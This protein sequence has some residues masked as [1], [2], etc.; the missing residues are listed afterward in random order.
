M[1]LADEREE[2]MK[3]SNCVVAVLVFFSFIAG[4]SFSAPGDLDLT[5]DSP[6]NTV[7]VL[8]DGLK[9][10]VAGWDEGER[11]LLLRRHNIDGTLDDTFGTGGVA[12]YYSQL[13][14]DPADFIVANA[15]AIQRD[16]K[17]VVVGG[18]YKVG[19]NPYCIVLRFTRDGGLD[20]TFGAEGAVIFEDSA[21]GGVAV[22]IQS[23]NKILV[24]TY[25]SISRYDS[26][27][28]LDMSF[29]TGGFVTFKDGDSGR[30][31]AMQSDGK[32]LIAGSTGGGAGIVV[33]RYNSNGTPD[34]NFGTEGAATHSGGSP[35]P[36][37]ALSIQPDGKIVVSGGTM[38]QEL[39]TPYWALLIEDAFI[40]RLNG[41]GTLDATFGENG[42]FTFRVPDDAFLPDLTGQW[43]SL[44]QTCRNTRTGLKCKISGRLNIQ[45]V[46]TL[47][48]PSSLVR[49][50]L[51]PDGVYNEGTDALKQVAT[52]AIKAAKSKTK[53][54]NYT[55]PAGD[56]ASGNYVIAVIDSDNTVAEANEDNNAIVFGPVP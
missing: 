44:T 38:H 24:V 10:I 25:G 52:G 4:P 46:G 33:L 43:T 26:A 42:V 15:V 55:F 21:E 2:W 32:I 37:L 20:R 19:S 45:N 50:Y 11:A 23:D 34:I 16:G 14:S 9:I 54:F 49:F 17:I 56:T 31:V 13:V 48:A 27:G 36:G 22:A 53:T 1:A 6:G 51:S 3:L 40:F 28:V 7:A 30:K 41:D 39:T 18:V 35:G 47:N 8:P 29:G 12:T 5:L